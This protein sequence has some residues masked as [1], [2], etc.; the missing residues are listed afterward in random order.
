MQLAHFRLSGVMLDAWGVAVRPSVRLKFMFHQDFGV[1]RDPYVLYV[2]GWMYRI[3]QLQSRLYVLPVL[4]LLL[5]LRRYIP[6][7]TERY[8]VISHVEYLY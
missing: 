4:G 2:Y 5:E 1:G 3:P 7:H 8:V 6:C